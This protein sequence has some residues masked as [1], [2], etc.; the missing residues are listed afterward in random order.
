[1]PA[2][3][4]PKR[5]LEDEAQKLLKKYKFGDFINTPAALDPALLAERM[6][7]TVQYRHL[8][9]DKH[10]YMEDCEASFYHPDT[11][12]MAP[13]NYHSR[14]GSVRREAHRLC[15]QHYRT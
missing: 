7:L 4:I 14:R 11:G 8:T 3:F 10:I 2:P 15:K 12:T 9:S 6:K 13:E 5:S 1:M